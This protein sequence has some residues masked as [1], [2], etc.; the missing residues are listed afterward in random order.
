MGYEVIH[1]GHI[2]AS[3]IAKYLA[4]H[5]LTP[6][7]RAAINTIA[8]STVSGASNIYKAQV[9]AQTSANCNTSIKFMRRDG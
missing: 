9:I 1:Y 3:L 2:W 7:I 6:W 4:V 8:K 5:T